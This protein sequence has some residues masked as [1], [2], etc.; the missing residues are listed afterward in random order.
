MATDDGGQGDGR[1]N[2]EVNQE[3]T[4]KVMEGSRE[5]ERLRRRRIDVEIAGGLR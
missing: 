1:A 4:V 3:L 5:P 2:A